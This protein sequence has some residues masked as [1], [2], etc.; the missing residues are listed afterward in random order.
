MRLAAHSHFAALCLMTGENRC[1][2]AWLDNRPRHSTDDVCP[3]TALPQLPASRCR[4]HHSLLNYLSLLH[5]TPSLCCNP[6]FLLQ[7]PLSA[8]AGIEM[9]SSHSTSGLA[10]TASFPSACR[11]LA[12][13]SITEPY[14]S[15]MKVLALTWVVKLQLHIN[16]I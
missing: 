4:N 6:L 2:R 15:M 11:Y 13:M 16:P 7:P 1:W 9:E 10:K 12:M 3:A 8:G 5:P 14:P